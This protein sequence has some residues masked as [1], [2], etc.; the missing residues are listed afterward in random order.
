MPSCS[1]NAH[2]V[3]TGGQAQLTISNIGQSDTM[4]F[5]NF[6]FSDHLLTYTADGL[7]PKQPTD[8]FTYTV[9]DPHGG[10]VTGT[11]HVTVTGPHRPTQVG[12]SGEDNLT[13]DGS[14][15][16]LIGGDGNDTLIA[17]GAH[18]LIFGGR[19][20]DTI[21]ANGAHSVV[22]GGPGTNTVTLDGNH[23]TVVLQWGGLDEISGFKLHGDVLD[24]KQVLAEEQIDLE[25]DIGRLAAY[26]TVSTSGQ[27]ATVSFNPDGIASGP[28]SALAVLHGIG[29]N[30]SLGTLLHDC[31]LIA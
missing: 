9:S 6:D 24:L 11:V 15:Q 28:G 2:E 27:D 18:Q 7:N 29:P 25:G 8:M 10:T 26:V 21:T 5:V 1:R 17:H 31:I 3:G 16:R 13:A 12:T 20:D 19:G 30:V 22:Y 14:G 23:E 4:G